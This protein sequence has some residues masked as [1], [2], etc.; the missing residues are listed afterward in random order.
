VLV[1]VTLSAHRTFP[2]SPICA[3]FDDFA[4][5]LA[6]QRE[7]LQREVPVSVLRLYNAAETRSLTGGGYGL[8]GR[9]LLLATVAGSAR[10]AEAGIADTLDTIVEAGGE[11]VDPVAGERWFT[12]RYAGIDL[13]ASR[14]EGTGTVF[15]T[16][17]VSVP[18]RSAAAVAEALEAEI[19]PLCA[20]LFLHSS[21]AY[22]SGTC[23]YAMLFVQ[24]ASD[25][26]ALARCREA[27]ERALD[28]TERHGGA[29]GHHHGIG[30]VRRERYAGS[31]DGRLHR[32]VK[33]AL[34]PSDILR[35]P[36]V[37]DSTP[38]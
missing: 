31:A 19:G 11:P 15:D 30:E 32:L 34:D 21:H 37:R 1:E 12:H 29:M 5:G 6:C 22:R 27:W 13:M 14:N 18:W 8:A 2:D 3:A 20:Q 25:G 10:R 7:L 23:L 36:L 24:A 9:C 38:R 33:R 28:L 17:E 4:S 35:A 26:E 16:I